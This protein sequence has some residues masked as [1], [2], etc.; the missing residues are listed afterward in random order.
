MEVNLTWWEQNKG[1]EKGLKRRSNSIEKL[2]QKIFHER[3]GETVKSRRKKSRSKCCFWLS[4][5]LNKKKRVK[6]KCTTQHLSIW[7]PLRNHLKFNMAMSDTDQRPMHQWE[8]LSNL[9]LHIT[10]TIQQPLHVKPFQFFSFL[11]HLLNLVTK[12]KQGQIN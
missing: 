1:P 10:T 4:N 3:N 12:L 9:P 6:E 2:V 7:M 5:V 11:K 8:L